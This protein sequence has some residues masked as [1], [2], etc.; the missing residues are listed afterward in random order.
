[1]NETSNWIED[2]ID[3]KEN[4]E[5]SH[6]KRES[7]TQNEHSS[8]KHSDNAIYLTTDIVDRR[9]TFI[10][11]DKHGDPHDSHLATKQFS[12]K[13]SFHTG[14]SFK[15]LKMSAFAV[16]EHGNEKFNKVI[17]TLCCHQPD[18]KW[19]SLIHGF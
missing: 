12:F 17:R 10:I 11:D 8:S 2:K 14:S 3:C 4:D 19:N 16:S 18:K 13:S 7:E 5:V 9:R 1:M 15:R 6:K